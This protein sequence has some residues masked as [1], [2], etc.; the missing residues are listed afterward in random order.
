[1]VFLRLLFSNRFLTGPM[2]VN[3][4]RGTFDALH[5]DWCTV[6]FILFLMSHD[7]SKRRHP[8]PLLY[9]LKLKVACHSL[10]FPPRL[11]I[12]Y[13]SVLLIRVW[14]GLSPSPTLSFPLGLSLPCPPPSLPHDCPINPPPPCPPHLH[15][16]SSN[17]LNKATPLPPWSSLRTPLQW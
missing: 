3:G 9:N 11:K 13:I 10:V 15:L 2:T 17:Q 5:A 6:Y 12:K 16:A 7:Y 8:G 14:A 1:M 4:R